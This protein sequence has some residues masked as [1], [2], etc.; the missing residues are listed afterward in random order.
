MSEIE[1][2]I[3]IEFLFGSILFVFYLWRRY[4]RNK[5]SKTGNGEVLG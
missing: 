5:K 2:T 4:K 3:P 1:I